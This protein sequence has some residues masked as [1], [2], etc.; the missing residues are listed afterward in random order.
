MQKSDPKVIWL[1]NSR[2]WGASRRGELT[3]A[4]CKTF[5]KSFLAAKPELIGCVGLGSIL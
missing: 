1:A 2:E 3:R 4:Q 5:P